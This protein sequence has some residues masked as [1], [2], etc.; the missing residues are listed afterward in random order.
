MKETI[1]QNTIRSGRVFDVSIQILII[2]SLISFSIETLPDLT[3]RTRELL[4]YVEIGTVSVFTIEYL[5]RILV[6]DR[7][8]KFMFSF[9]GLVDLAAILPFYLAT[10]LDLRSVRILRLLRLFRI[11]KL[12][13][14]STAIHRF[15]TA[16]II[17]KEELVLF[18]MVAMMLFFFAAVG[19]YYFENSAQPELFASVFHSLW[20]AVITLTTVGYGDVYPVTV[21]GRIFTFFVL[22]IGLGIIAV[23]TG[24][25]A[26][27]LSKARDVEGESQQSSV[28]KVVR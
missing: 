23:P 10:G 13:R 5:L 26:S 7:R 6:A 15:H 19:V 8:L 21:G 12:V 27:A 20:W 9:Y 14:Y 2:V 11:F 22:M 24:I 3:D 18:F 25:L 1:E 4:R 16:F 17:A 28:E